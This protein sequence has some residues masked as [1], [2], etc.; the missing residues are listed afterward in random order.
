MEESVSPRRQDQPTPTLAFRLRR[1]AAVCRSRCRLGPSPRSPPRRSPECAL[2]TQS[3]HQSWSGQRRDPYA[4]RATSD[5]SPH[6]DPDGRCPLLDFDSVLALGG[7]LGLIDHWERLTKFGVMLRSI[8]KAKKIAPRWRSW[9]NC[10]RTARL[11]LGRRQCPTASLRLVHA[12]SFGGGSGSQPFRQAQCQAVRRRT[13]DVT[14]G[15]D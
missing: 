14:C 8:R 10:L 9:S 1:A 13:H 2:G 11:N 4:A 15:G 7:D 3:R 5:P 6:G 12:T